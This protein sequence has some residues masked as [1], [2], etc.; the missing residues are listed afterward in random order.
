MKFWIFLV[1]LYGIL[2][3]MRD[4][5]K[6]KA[7]QQSQVMEVLFFFSLLSFLFVTS[8][9][10]EALKLEPYYILLITLKTFFVFSAWILG[11]NAIKKNP[12]KPLRSFGFVGSAFFQPLWLL[13]F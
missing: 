1:I 2:K 5:F 9:A 4:L 13:F 6:K 8:E 7:L 10:G 12:R 11:F 3:G